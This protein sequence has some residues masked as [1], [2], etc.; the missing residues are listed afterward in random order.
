M[1]DKGPKMCATPLVSVLMPCYNHEAYVINSMESVAASDYELIEFIFIDD[2]SQ[3]NSYSLASKWFEENK[4]RFVRTV[5]I[6]HEKNRGI[7]A[8]FNELYQLSRGDYV[9]YLASDDLMLADGISRQINFAKTYEVDFVFSDCLL[10][11]ESGGLIS[12]SAINY[13][14]RPERRLKRK[15]CLSAE[16]IYF[17]DAPW[18][19]FFMKSA[20]VQKIGPFDESLSYEDRDFIVRVL[21]NGSFEFMSNATTAYRIRMNNRL[22]PGLVQ[23]EVMR[24]F[25]MADC[26]NYLGSSGI[27]RLLLSVVVFSY[28]YKYRELGIKNAMF[29]WFAARVVRVFKKL[30]LMAHRVLM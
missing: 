2:A 26:K 30:V 11:D 22:T 21:I 8:T 4:G 19:K 14:G 7:C 29:I 6:Q 18:N 9:S 24:D 20:L 10:I 1:T 3:D 27:T 17:W 28:E 25:Y 23:E 5:C 12:N 16:I 15:T 13:F